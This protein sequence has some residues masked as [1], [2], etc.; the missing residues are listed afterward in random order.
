MF[1]EMAFEVLI[2]KAI[3]QDPTIVNT[4]DVIK[5]ATC[6]AQPIFPNNSYV[7]TLEENT[8]ADIV[9]IDLDSPNTTPVIDPVSH[10]CHAVGREQVK[11]TV[12]DGSIVYHN[13][14]FLTLD[15]NEV[16]NNAQRITDRLLDR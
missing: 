1:E 4:A 16:K 3:H 9:V 8:P 14:Q 5:M 15:V 11:M 10:I 6:N 13:G 2:H 12:V 7:G